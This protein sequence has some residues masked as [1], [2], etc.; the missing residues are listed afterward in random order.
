MIPSCALTGLTQQQFELI[1]LH[2]LAHIRRHDYLINLFQTIIETIL[3]YH[4]A[5]WWVSN[6]IRNERENAC[7]DLAV[8][9]GGDAVTY[10]RTLIEIERLRKANP[11]FALAADGGSLTM[12]IH[13]LIN[14]EI[15]DSKHSAGIWTVIFICVFTTTVLVITQ[16]SSINKEPANK[17]LQL[18]LPPLTIEDL[19]EGE[20][21]AQ[22]VITGE[23][24]AEFNPGK[25]D[26][27]QLHIR[28]QSK[29]GGINGSRNTLSLNELEGLAP[30]VSSSSKTN[31]N[32]KI[33]REAGTFVFEGYFSEGKGTGFWKLTPS[34][35]FVSDMRSRGY[36]NLPEN[37]LFY[38]ATEDINAKLIDDLES[39]GYI[40]SFKELIQ[41]ASYKITPES[42]QAW[43]EAGFNNL[44]F[45]ELA[46]LG[47]HDVTLEYI[48]EIKAEG[49]PQI[50]LSQAIKLKDHEVDRDFIR[51]VKAK[52][53]P[54]ITLEKLIKLQIQGIV[55]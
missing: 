28:K 12:R 46:T 17:D 18:Y 10:A 11:S 44:S 6:Q 9:I 54:N 22:N 37:Y 52:G 33:L 41:A 1:L 38:A 20:H 25:S 15:T 5:V 34:Q 36:D 4:P 49:F 31:V 50:T 40:L 48:E 3:F 8:N 2:E 32:F 23:W 42:F 55:R 19:R 45:K 53:F 13:R 21:A 35:T 51:Q 29:G 39:G 16:G 26:E 47:E 14:T 30:D 43:R 27:I 7:D 24:T